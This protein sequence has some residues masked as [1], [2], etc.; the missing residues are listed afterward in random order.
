MGLNIGFIVDKVRAAI[1]ST[2]LLIRIRVLVFSKVYI[3][4]E[5]F[6]KR[7]V[8]LVLLFVR[9]MGILVT[10][11]ELVFLIVGWDGLGVTS[12][13]LILYYFN[14]KRLRGAMFTIFRNRVGDAFI[15]VSVGLFIVWGGGGAETII[16]NK[17]GWGGVLL[18]IRAITKRAQIPF[19]A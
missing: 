19:R 14:V 16:V 7:F 2:V 13:L 17:R 12:F 8:G 1:L 10:I 5:V 11:T 4:E 6:K 15:I 9:S 18:V 3:K